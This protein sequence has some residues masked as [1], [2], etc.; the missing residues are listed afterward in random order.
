[1]WDTCAAYYRPD[2]RI[3]LALTNPVVAAPG[4]PEA[5]SAISVGVYSWGTGG[6]PQVNHVLSWKSR[7]CSL[8]SVVALEASVR[9]LQLRQV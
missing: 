5:S 8:P 9:K 3:D 4:I 2:G 1:M 6:M 7:C